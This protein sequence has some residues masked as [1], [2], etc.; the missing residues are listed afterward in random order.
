MH[1]SR[2][3]VRRSAFSVTIVCGLLGLATEPAPA[4]LLS[5]IDGNSSADF[6]TSSS[7]NN[8]NWFV[9]GVDRLSQQAFWYRVGGVGPELSVHSLAIGV[10]GTTDSNFDGNPDTLFVRYVGAGF[11]VE[12]RYTLD[13]GTPGSGASDLAEQISIINTGE[14]ALD[15]HFFQYADFDLSAA[16]SILFTNANTV[17]QSGPGSEL[18]E[19]VVT[20]VPSH[21]EG[22][23]FPVTLNELNDALPTTLNDLPAIGVP[24]GAGDMTWAYQWDVL[25]NPGDTFQISK[26]K[27]LKPI[28]PEPGTALA[29]AAIGI[30]SAVRRRSR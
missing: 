2:Q 17:R 20:P 13:G 15:Y 14:S 6:D 21:R 9:D 12:T 25:I 18:T 22:G 19:T 11:N 3:N 29:I 23:F 5:L 28:V 16:D 26:D 8:Y 7:G 4:A 10:Q 30:L 1:P 27:N 24:I